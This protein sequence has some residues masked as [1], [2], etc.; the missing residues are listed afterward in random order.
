MPELASATMHDPVYRVL[1]EADGYLTPSAIL[2]K[3]MVPYDAI[4]LERRIAHP[5]KDFVIEI[6]DTSAGPAYRL[7]KFNACIGQDD[8]ER[9]EAFAHRIGRSRIS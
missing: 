7:G 2:S 5:S 3:L 1:K 9:H 6:E 8:H 4:Q